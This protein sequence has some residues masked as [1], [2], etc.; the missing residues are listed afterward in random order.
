MTNSGYMISAMWEC[1]WE[2]IVKENSE[3]KEHVECYS[4]SSTLTHRDM[5]DVK[6]L[7]CMRVVLTHM[8]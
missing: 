8:S 1:E 5:V 4:L 3:N 7:V 2:N 6:H